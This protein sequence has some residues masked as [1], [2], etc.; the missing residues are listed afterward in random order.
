VVPA[1]A[2]VRTGDVVMLH[3]VDVQDGLLYGSWWNDGLV[4][5][6]VGNGIK[7]SAPRGASSARWCPPTPRAASRTRR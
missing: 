1:T 4:I 7:V 2:H 5:L 6:D 3:D